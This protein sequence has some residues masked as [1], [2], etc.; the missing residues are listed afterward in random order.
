MKSNWCKYHIKSQKSD[1]AKKREKIDPFAFF[2]VKKE[3]PVRLTILIKEGR[4]ISKGEKST[5]VYG[6]DVRPTTGY[7]S[8]V[9]STVSILLFVTIRHLYM[10]S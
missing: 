9:K 7:H 4:N 3:L 8:T 5:D 1:E 2:E 6:P 10:V